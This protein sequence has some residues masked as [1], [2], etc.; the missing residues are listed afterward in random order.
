ME[1][2]ITWMRHLIIGLAVINA[3]LITSCSSNT[4]ENLIFE[5]FKYKNQSTYNIVLTSFNKNNIYSYQMNN[6]ADISEKQ[7]LLFGVIDSL[8]INSDSLKVVFDS[9]KVLKIYPN[10]ETRFN[11]LNREN[12]IYNFTGNQHLYDYTFTIDDYNEAE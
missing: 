10:L 11:I 3:I 5:N 2:K 4:N 8:I 12:Y 9:N 7:E 6:N 1:Q